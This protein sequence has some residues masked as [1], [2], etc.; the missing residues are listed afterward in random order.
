MFWLDFSNVNWMGSTWYSKPPVFVVSVGWFQV[1]TWKKWLEITISIHLKLG[2]FRVGGWYESFPGPLFLNRLEVFLFL[3][4]MIF[5]LSINGA[6]ILYFQSYEAQG[7][8][9]KGQNHRTGRS[10]LRK[11]RFF[12]GWY[13]WWKKSC[14]T[15]E[16]CNL[17]NNGI[18]DYL[19]TG[20]GFLPSTVWCGLHNPWKAGETLG[21]WKVFFWK[22]RIS[23]WFGSLFFGGR[24]PKT[25]DK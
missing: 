15:R 24:A 22:I 20:A 23:W 2:L 12:P 16:V 14:T 21:S 10:H 4:V 11:G 19:S 3:L 25:S 1:F 9:R 5:V 17:V 6:A 8:F 13:C 7:W 18:V